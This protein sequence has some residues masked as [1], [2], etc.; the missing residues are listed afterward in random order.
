MVRK[1][2]TRRSLLQ[3]VWGMNIIISWDMFPYDV[4]INENAAR[5]LEYAYNDWCIW[6][7]AKQLGR[8]K[9]NWIYMPVVR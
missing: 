3:D 2:F 9:R 7:I 8:P 1:T 5:T 4:K 6:Q